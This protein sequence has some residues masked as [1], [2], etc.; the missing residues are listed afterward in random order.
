MIYH[1]S[2]EELHTMDPR[3]PKSA[4]SDFEDTKTPRVCFSTTINGAL[5]GIQEQF[6]KME[7]EEYVSKQNEISRHNLF[8]KDISFQKKS[9]LRSVE[10]LENENFSY[11]MEN[12]CLKYPRYNVY[13][14]VYPVD[15]DIAPVFDQ[16]ITDEVWVKESVIVQK[17]GVIYVTEVTVAGSMKCKLLNGKFKSINKYFYEYIK[18]PPDHL[19]KL[20]LYFKSKENTL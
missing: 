9:F 8:E 16:L 18:L 17:I 11:Y 1:L 5:N 14:P 4:M 6:P 10:D 7:N 13:T 15:Y 2:R 3:I 12:G 19:S 20:E